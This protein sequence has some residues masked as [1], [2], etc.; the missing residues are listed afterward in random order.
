MSKKLL[1]LQIEMDDDEHI[2]WNIDNAG[3]LCV[4]NILY[5]LL[6]TALTFA[7]E[8]DIDFFET[9]DE[10]LANNFEEDEFDHILMAPSS[11][12]IN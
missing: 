11:N 8:Q 2:S 7:I 9:V 12:A 6:D 5:A 4:H 1:T 3:D 10:M